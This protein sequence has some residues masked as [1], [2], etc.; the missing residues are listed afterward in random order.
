MHFNH[1]YKILIQQKLTSHLFNLTQGWKLGSSNN[2]EF[3][4]ESER[5]GIPDSLQHE[6]IWIKAKNNNCIKKND[7]ND[8]FLLDK[9]CPTIFHWFEN[10][11]LNFSYR[12]KKIHIVTNHSLDLCKNCWSL[13]RK[14]TNSVQSH[15]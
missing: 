11:E 13:W 7:F 15:K 5:S 4:N 14:D 6:S 1:W 8:K 3:T 10:W 12:R 2:L 9:S